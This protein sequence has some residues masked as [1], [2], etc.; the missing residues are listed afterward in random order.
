MQEAFVLDASA[1]VIST[2]YKFLVES[3]EPLVSWTMAC[4][5]IKSEIISRQFASLSVVTQLHES[6][7]SDEER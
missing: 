6:R 1:P 4:E 3:C 5:S 7:D 2:A